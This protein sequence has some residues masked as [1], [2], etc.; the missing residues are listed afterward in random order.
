MLLS[1]EKIYVQLNACVNQCNCF[2]KHGYYHRQNHLYC[3]L[4]AAREKEDKEAE[5]QILA[6]IQW[7][8]DRTFWQCFNYALGKPWGGTC[9]KVQVKEREGMVDEINSNEDLHEAIWVNVHRKQFYLAE[10]SLWALVHSGVPL[11]TTQLLLQPGPF[12]REHTSTL[13]NL[14]MQP[15]SY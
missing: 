11:D 4:E 6:I 10:E 12:W 5:W 3:H 15:R 8:K 7:E 9:F 1:I 2:R 13:Q 14:I